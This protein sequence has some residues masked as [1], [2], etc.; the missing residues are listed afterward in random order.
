MTMSEEVLLKIGDDDYDVDFLWRLCT[1]DQAQDYILKHRNMGIHKEIYYIYRDYED[2][3]YE[4]IDVK[5][6][7]DQKYISA[8]KIVYPDTIGIGNLGMYEDIENNYE[9]YKSG[10]DNPCQSCNIKCSS[11]IRITCKY[12]GFMLCQNCIGKCVCQKEIQK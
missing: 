11:T 6:I 5:I 12:C 7:T 3:N 9:E 2:I 4:D 10:W 1:L 8:F